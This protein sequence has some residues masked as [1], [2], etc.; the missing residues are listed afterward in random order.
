M[1]SQIRALCEPFVA[2]WIGT[3]IW[4]LTSMGSQVSP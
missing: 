4:L 1:S 2:T 3:K